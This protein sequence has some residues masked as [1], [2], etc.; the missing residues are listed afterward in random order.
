MKSAFPIAA[1]SQRP[2]RRS[3]VA[4][5]V[6][7]RAHT[8]SRSSARRRCRCCFG[9]PAREPR[10]APR[11][12]PAAA[13]RALRPRHRPPAPAAAMIKL[14]SVKAR[15]GAAAAFGAR[16]A[17]AARRVS[18][19]AR[20][21]NVASLAPRHRRR[22][23]RRRRPPTPPRATRARGR[24]RASCAWPKARSAARSAPRARPGL[25]S[26]ALNTVFDAR[27]RRHLGAQPGAHHQR[28]LPGRQGEAAEL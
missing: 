6:V 25:P 22:S 4:G 23:R 16:F 5:R 27:T 1:A 13:E 11:A 3:Q 17:G 15:C 24:R 8:R 14:F 28:A 19:C 21:D 7:R 26:L 18:A 2:E 10:R 9:E 20:A 12:L